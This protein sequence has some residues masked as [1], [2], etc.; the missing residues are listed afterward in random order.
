MV[1][2]VSPKIALAF[3]A[4]C[5]VGIAFTLY[6]FEIYWLSAITGVFGVVYIYK[7]IR[8]ML[9]IIKIEQQMRAF[10]LGEELGTNERDDT[11][12]HS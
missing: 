5:W 1:H 3:D 8:V 11:D 7:A 6:Y 2:T 4:L 10:M 9:E 12:E